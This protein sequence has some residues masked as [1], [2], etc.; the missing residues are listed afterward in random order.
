V[1]TLACLYSLRVVAGAGAAEVELSFWLLA[2]CAYGFLSLA[3]LK[4]YAELMDE[5]QQECL[6]SRAY[7]RGD[8]PVVLAL[9]VGAGMVATVVMALYLE[10]QTA[11]Q[12][13]SH[14]KLLWCLV[15]L[16]TLAIGRLWLS[17]GRGEMHD[18]PIVFIARDPA[19]LTIVG[20]AILAIVL[21]I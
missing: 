11:G 21:A 15:G 19:S 14:Q 20:L 2:L 18:D 13:Y 3:L 6:N 4:R 17:A 7:R 8:S 12:L 5:D 1:A 9:G 10:S 16:M